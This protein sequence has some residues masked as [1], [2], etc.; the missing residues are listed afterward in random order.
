MKRSLPLFTVL[1]VLAFSVIF[2]PSALAEGDSR[3]FTDKKGQ[4]IEAILLAVAPDWKTMK[5]RR[6]DG[7]EFGYEI[8]NLCLDDQQFI[9]D[10]IKSHPIK[11]DYRLD[12]S[13]T[14]KLIDT[15]KEKSGSGSDTY[16]TKTYEAEI[17]LTNLSR[18]TLPYPVISYIIVRDE[19]VRFFE[20][21]DG[22]LTYNSR[23]DSEPARLVTFR[24]EIK[25]EEMVFNREATIT[26]KKFQLNRFDFGFDETFYEDKLTSVLVQ[27]KTQKGALIKEFRSKGNSPEL[28]NMTWDDVLE[29]ARD[30]SE[31]DEEEA[32]PRAIGM[33]EKGP[34]S[35]SLLKGDTI[36]GP[37]DVVKMPITIKAHVGP[38]SSAKNG[39]IVSIGAKK[40]GLAILI[41]GDQLIGLQVKDPESA[42]VMVRPPLGEFDVELRLSET[43]LVIFVDG[44]EESSVTSLGLFELPSKRGIEV[45]Q[46]TAPTLTDNEEPFAFSGK[47][48]D[49][50]VEI[51]P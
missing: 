41:E 12:I 7:G 39:A 31:I 37:I 18:D 36:R 4:K 42:R 48:E 8:V 6:K 32:T 44:R 46:D 40:Q 45:G 15:E 3:V 5:I 24:G 23:S 29:L 27:V 50:S 20:D 21:S 2:P 47:I 34:S 51:G 28:E 13:V 22:D 43:K 1:C 33:L 25:G 26:T 49:A 38:A 11:A 10:W 35:H 16:E 9:K 14:G 17:H 19:K 30:P